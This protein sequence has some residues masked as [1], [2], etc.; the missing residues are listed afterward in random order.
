[1]NAQING[2]VKWY[3][4]E[5]AYG[6]ITTEQGEDVFV[7][8]NSIADGRPH[9][10]DG[11]QVIL[12]VRQGMKGTEAVDVQVVVDVEEIPPARVRAYSQASNYPRSGAVRRERPGY[13]GPMP[14]G[15]VGATVLR[16][17]AAGR[18]LFAR[19]DGTD[20]DVYVHCSLYEHADLRPS[21]GSRIKIEVEQTERG[22]RAV[23]LQHA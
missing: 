15:H 11:Q 3:D 7:H 8:R 1:M 18:F 12:A 17:D 10:V 16:I 5:K 13:Q 22:P 4:P 23:S 6:F 20:L 14:R 9:L 2:T 19:I 21:E